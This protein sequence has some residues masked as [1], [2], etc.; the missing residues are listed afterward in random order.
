M[1]TI[2][3]CISRRSLKQKNP[4]TNNSL[5]SNNTI[6]KK[7][8]LIEMQAEI[9]KLEAEKEQIAVDQLRL[10]QEKV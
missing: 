7:N 10:A 3:S 8:S 1:T 6:T 2:V 4:C 5:I 9:L